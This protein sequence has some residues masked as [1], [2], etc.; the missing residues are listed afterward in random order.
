VDT[1]VFD[2]TGTLTFGTPEVTSI[3]AADG[4][5][6]QEVQIASIA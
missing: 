5:T 6:E 2:K 1:V 3:L 4:H